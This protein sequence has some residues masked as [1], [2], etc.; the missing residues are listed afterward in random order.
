MSNPTTPRLEPG[1]RL[2]PIA[3][4]TEHGGWGLLGAPIILGLWT[5]PSVA[6]VWLSLAA[7]GAFLA[8]QP[9]K[10][11]LGD[12]R[13]GKR[14]PRTVLAERFALGYG[15]VALVA[16]SAAWFTSA[17]P[18]WLPLLLAAPLAAVQLRFDI[19][20]LSRALAAELCGAAAISATAA[21]L[22]LAG[23]WTPI[24]ALLLWLLLALQST[25]AIVYVGIRLRL[26]RGAPARRAPALLLHLGALVLVGG[27]LWSGLIG[28]PVLASFVL[29]TLRCCIGLMP[30]SLRTPTPLVGLQELGWSLLMVI[31]I[32]LGM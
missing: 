3:L 16:F 18:F 1:G 20:K 2:R 15:I 22:A 25:T 11:A 28:W 4:P 5:A 17:Y 24:P 31:G 12:W 8:R 27:L 21:A 30:R 10:L 32:R 23:G 9:L 29:L 6:G 7:L 14:F 19:L 26:A 13:R